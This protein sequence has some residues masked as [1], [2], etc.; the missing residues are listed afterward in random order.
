MAVSAIEDLKQF[1]KDMDWIFSHYEKLKL[2]YP[3]QYI[4]VFKNNLIDHDSEMKGLMAR[5]R[6]KYGEQA[7]SIAV[8]FITAKKDELIL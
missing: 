1:E 4:A 5:L 2:R 6:R 8:E 3:E 7:A